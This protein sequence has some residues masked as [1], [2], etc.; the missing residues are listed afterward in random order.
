MNILYFNTNSDENDREFFDSEF[1]KWLMLLLKI[2]DPTEPNSSA[3]FKLFSEGRESVLETYRDIIENSVSAY[4]A[5]VAD[6]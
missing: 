3:Y 6:T 2:V 1:H 4:N 5:C